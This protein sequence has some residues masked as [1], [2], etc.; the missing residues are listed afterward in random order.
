MVVK[1]FNKYLIAIAII[2]FC[3]PYKIITAQNV[4]YGPYNGGV[5]QITV[6][7]TPS[8]DI[9]TWSSSQA[10]SIPIYFYFK[11]D[12]NFPSTCDTAE[13]RSQFIDAW[14]IWK[15]ASAVFGFS[16]KS[17]AQDT[18]IATF[19][20][21]VSKFIQPS[22]DLSV[23]KLTVVPNSSASSGWQIVANSDSRVYFNNT[24]DFTFN[25]YSFSNNLSG[26]DDNQMCFK[27]AA[28][29]EL[30]HVIGI[31][32]FPTYNDVMSKTLIT[33]TDFYTLDADDETALSTLD[34]RTEI[35]TGIEDYINITEDLNNYDVN[36]LYVGH[37][38]RN[39]V[40]VYPYGDY[41][42]NWDNWKITASYG[43]GSVVLY[44][45]SSPD[46][47]EIPDP[48]DGYNW[49]RDD[50]GYVIGTLSTGGTDEDGFNHTA[51]IPIKISGVSNTF[52]TSGTLTSDTTYW[53]GDIHITGS[54][55]VPSGK[56][57]I[58]NP[59][60]IVSFPNNAS[61]IVNGDLNASNCTFRSQSGTS[62]N[63]WGNIELSGSGA[64]DS[65]IQNTNIQYG[66]G[67][68]VLNDP[69]FE[70]TD[71]D[72]TDNQRSI[73][74]YNSTGLIQDNYITTN[75]TGHGIQM[76]GASSVDCLSNVV[77]K[78]NHSG[79]GIYYGGGSSG[80]VWQNDITGWG[81]GIGAIWGS[82]PTSYSSSSFTKNNRVTNCDDGLMVY[83]DSYPIFG[84]PT[85]PYYRYNSL[86]DNT[87]NASVGMSYTSYSSSLTA[88]D[89][90]WGSTSPNT[91]LFSVGPNG[92]L[93]YNPYLTSDPWNGA[94]L[95]SEVQQPIVKDTAIALAKSTSTASSVKDQSENTSISSI[96]N[97]SADIDSILIGINLRNQNKYKE[98]MDYFISYLS[99]HPDNQRAYVELY[100]CADSETIPIIINFFKSLPK[101]ASND[102]QLL[103][104]YL[105]LKQGE[106]NLA[107]KVND[108]IIAEGSNTSLAERAMINNAYIDLFNENN[109]DDA[110]KLYNQ[111]VNKPQLSTPRELADLQNT[112]GA[113]IVA[114][115]KNISDYPSLEKK[116]ATKEIIPNK[117]ALLENYPN[118]FNPT[119]TIA[120]DLPVTSRVEI[121]IYD[122]LGKEVRRF[123]IS[124]QSA[125]RQ[126][127]V[128]NGRNDNNEEV[129]S[130]VYLYHFKATA[131]ESKTKVFEKSSKL[132]LMK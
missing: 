124:S 51:S 106:I 32:D 55:T 7:P 101:Q 4:F 28:L 92:Y 53:C 58:V 14:A 123:D 35:L 42:V 25:G 18:Y 130:G 80:H 89:N 1:I 21:D 131:L 118:P 29:H 46:S 110:V 47:F 37:I 31:G 63:S 22:S 44:D 91:S 86:Y 74:T 112:I 73:Y 93:G 82:S 38:D 50:N 43:C 59:D 97:S 119:T 62:P 61:L 83:R 57:L 27:E 8:S 33:G 67:I 113:S 24:S 107:K 66:S 76:D 78:T 41:I 95:P 16:E 102:N 60:A 129:S 126:G 56:T 34:N 17:N 116:I 6:P 40:D 96:G 3:L 128:W 30:G 104:S 45:D 121:T 2:S 103:L 52:I 20:T 5:E 120:Y 9:I 114:G 19:T 132:I 13:C 75:S 49:Q 70:I 68:Q 48:P 87:I 125:G 117:Y 79:V 84:Q 11:S 108:M 65:Y 36:Y 81:W 12:P 98:A 64:S 39:F 72:F 69:N 94:P 100:D 99:R 77:V 115:G 15:Q 71:C 88:Y 127:V 85:N 111:A 23:T 105:Y 122:I 26:L 10:G 109:L 90:W 54:I